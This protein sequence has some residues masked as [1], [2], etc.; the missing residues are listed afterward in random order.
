M[1]EFP[2]KRMRRRRTSHTLRSLVR[3]T[4][5]AVKNL[6]YPMFVVEDAAAAGP[7]TSMPGI[8]R[9]CIDSFARELEEIAATG[10]SAVLLFGIPAS[11]DADASRADADDGIIAR[12]IEKARATAP[13]IL[14]ATDVCLCSYTNHGHCGLMQ[15]KRILNDASLERLASMALVHAQA[16]ADIVAPSA[17]L[18][19]Q[20]QAI[21]NALDEADLIDTIIMS[22]AAKYASSFYGPF[23][24]AADSAPAFGDRRGYQMDPANVAEALAETRLDLQEGA[25]V[26]MVK[27][28]MPYLDVVTRVKQAF[29]EAPLAAYQ[30]SGEYSMIKAA[31]AAGWLDEPSVVL[32]S[33]TAIKRAGADILISYFAKNVA[34]HLH[35]S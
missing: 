11:K 21:R 34:R 14:I 28:A 16:G 3:E 33:L 2:L 20:V 12:A 22:Y 9:L 27:P 6:V 24:E 23:R 35:R 32:E 31:A 13:D 4:R 26:V 5:L 7:I 1:A 15:D 10:V 17:M 25:D 18:D 30:V 8:D 29:P 19:G